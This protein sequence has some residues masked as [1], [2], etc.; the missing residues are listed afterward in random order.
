MKVLTWLSENWQMLLLNIGVVIVGLWLL[1]LIV[2]I[3]FAL[4]FRHMLKKV[5]PAINLLLNQ[6]HDNMVELIKLLKTNKVEIDKKLIDEIDGL[7]RID[8]FQKLSKEDRDSRVLGFIHGGHAL[9]SLGK[10]NKE[11]SKSEEFKEINMLFEEIENTY[12]QKVADYNYAVVGYNYWVSVFFVKFAYRLF[13]IKP[14]DQ[15]V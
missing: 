5:G 9:I 14:L 10:T 15:I 1:A 12:R 6:R 11:V 4:I 2:T 7:E 8:D 3:V 13:R